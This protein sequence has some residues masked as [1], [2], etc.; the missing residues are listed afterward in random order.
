MKFKN[1]AEVTAVFGM[2]FTF[3]QRILV[4]NYI[5]YGIRPDPDGC[6]G[7]DAAYIRIL[8]SDMDRYDGPAPEMRT[9]DEV[10]ADDDAAEA[11]IINVSANPDDPEV[12]FAETFA[13]S[14]EALKP[15]TRKRK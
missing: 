8:T 4:E 14:K 9:K 10:A 13:T 3:E 2:D 12:D 6:M 11:R 1:A 5:Q 7:C 15:Q